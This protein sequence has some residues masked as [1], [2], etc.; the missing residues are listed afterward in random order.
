MGVHHI[1]H[2]FRVPEGEFNRLISK[3]DHCYQLHQAYQ[4]YIYCVIWLSEVVSLY[5][6]IACCLTCL[7]LIT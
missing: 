1:F 2:V 6:I 5:Y 7:K 4:T 3:F